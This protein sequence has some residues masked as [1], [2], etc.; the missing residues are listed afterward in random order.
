MRHC[1]EYIEI[2]CT[3][4]VYIIILYSHTVTLNHQ[5]L[6][7]HIEQINSA[8]LCSSHAK[9]VIAADL[10]GSSIPDAKL[11]RDPLSNTCQQMLPFYYQFCP[12]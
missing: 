8:V 7:I 6:A 3:D 9:S 11:R 5:N 12:P 2:P 10:S 1:Y 4:R